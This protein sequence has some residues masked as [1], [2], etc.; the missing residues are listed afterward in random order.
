M[1][2]QVEG[3]LHHKR[4]DCGVSIGLIPRIQTYFQDEQPYRFTKAIHNYA[5][6]NL[7]PRHLGPEYVIHGA[8]LYSPWDPAR[9]EITLVISEWFFDRSLNLIK[10]LD[11]KVGVTGRAIS[12]CSCRF[13][14]VIAATV[15][16]IH[17]RAFF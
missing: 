16:L 5:A 3:K 2:E 7:I 8:K 17:L 6:T 9:T 12:R 10:N 15:S 14:D 1:G 13:G 11:N 4:E